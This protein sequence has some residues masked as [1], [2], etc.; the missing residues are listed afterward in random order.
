LDAKIRYFALAYAVRKPDDAAFNGKEGKHM[1]FFAEN[2]WIG[3]II[4]GGLAGM[5]GKL[6]MPGND[7]GGVIITIIL[8]IAGALLMGLLGGLTGWYSSGEGPD[9]IAAVIGSIILLIGYRL[10]RKNKG[11]TPPST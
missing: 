1:D 8:G 4:I 7:G 5:V 10:V 6:L 9:F 11:G 2:G 3:W